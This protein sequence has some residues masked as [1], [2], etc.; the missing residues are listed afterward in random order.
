MHPARP[1]AARVFARHGRL[2]HAA[3]AHRFLDGRVDRVE[4][5]IARYDLVQGSRVRVFLKDDKMLEQG[6]EALLLKHERTNTSSSSAVF[7]AS[8]SPSIVRQ[9]LNHS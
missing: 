3:G 1:I 8:P 6:E 9:T 4:L 7:G 2:A 5:M